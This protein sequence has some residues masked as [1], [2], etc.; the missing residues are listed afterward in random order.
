MSNALAIAGVTAVIRDLLDSGMI[1]HA[2]TDTVGQGVTVTAIAPDRIPLEGADARPQLNVF[3]HQATPNAALRNTGLPSRDRNGNR[4]SNPP[5]ALDLHYL[6]TAYGAT[7]L[8][9]EVLLGYAMQLL[10]E[11]PVL[12]R[13]KIR[14]ALN[15]PSMPVDGGELPSVYQA[16][17]ASDLADQY[18]QV[19]IS[20]APMST[21]EMS[22]LW[23]A[24]QAHY[25]PTAAYDVSVV[26]IEAAQPSRLPLPVL[27]RGPRVPSSLDPT[28]TIESGVRVLADLMPPFPEIERI[29][30][31]NAQAGAHLGDTIVLHGHHFDGTNHRVLLTLPKL[32]IELDIVPNSVTP[33]NAAF[34][35]SN[36]PATF[37]AGT[38]LL[39]L[40]VVMPGD[41]APR[42][43]NQVTL[44]IAPQIT[45]L[46]NPPTSF[47]VD[48]DST[49]TVNIDCTPEV[50]PTQTVSLML[51]SLQVAADAHPTQVNTLTFTIPNAPVGVHRARL[52]VDG[53]DS[54]IVNRAASP[55]VFFDHWIEIA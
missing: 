48:A 27:S 50:W 49:A 16:L 11:T 29:T 46:T 39:S 21:D 10:H 53:A 5:L 45:S 14:I 8:Q 51:G 47:A 6:V 26:L 25:R 54:Q 4:I 12:S 30:L 31:P 17:R 40:E 32:R 15:P 36:L 44:T 55:P 43:S 33:T 20:P 22:K 28:V 38:Y 35:L 23:S 42:T 2:V 1:D 19:K 41:T 3:L 7:D 18:E 37:P 9:A 24:C 34:L 13:D 52:R